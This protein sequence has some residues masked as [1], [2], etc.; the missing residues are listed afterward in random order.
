MFQFLQAQQANE[1]YVIKD[2]Y[3][4]PAFDFIKFLLKVP[5]LQ[6]KLLSLQAGN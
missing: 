5:V 2:F 3:S 1:H 4:T 6:L